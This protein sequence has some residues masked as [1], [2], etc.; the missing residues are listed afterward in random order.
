VNV[1]SGIA[2][3]VF[4]IAAI[5]LLKNH[6]TASAF[7]VVLDIAISTTL[8]SY[9]WIFP[10][11]LKLRYS[12]PDVP[13]PFVHPW[14]M[15]GIWVSTVLTTGWILL[16]SW[17]AVWPDTLERLFG[18]GYKFKDSWGVSQWEFEGLTLGTLGII[19]GVGL[20]GYWAGR[21]VRAQAATVPIGEVIP[22]SPL[23]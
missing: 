14:G 15:A 21:E 7:T 17:V 22:P 4:A 11:V 3:S 9:L 20:I 12:H 1:L 16:G 6:S 2:S 18:V 19:V 23:E 10:A 5:S 13:R 8:I